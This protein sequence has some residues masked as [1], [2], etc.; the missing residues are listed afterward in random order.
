MV[1]ME[2]QMASGDNEK[3]KEGAQT[4]S[5]PK[6]GLTRRDALLSISAGALSTGLGTAPAMAQMA[7]GHREVRPG[8]PPLKGVRV[9]ERSN[10][11]SGRLAGMLLADQGAE[12]FV[13]RSGPTSSAD[14]GVALDD[15]FFDRGKIAL[16]PGAT[17]DTASAD[18]IIVDGEAKVARASHQILVRVVAALPGDDT[19]GDLPADCSED[20][21][22]A[23]C[24][25]F[26]DM[27]ISGPLL[28]RPVIY[29]PIPL[30]SVYCGVNA[31]VAAVA[32]LV[33]R[34]RTGLGREI[35]AS[36]I[37]GGLS[38]VGALSLTSKG[39]P[40]QLEPIV[41]GGLPPGLS[42]DQF[43]T[44]VAD[45]IRDPERQMWFERR[46]APFST[47]Y[48]TKDGRWYLPMAG[49]NARLSKRLLEAMGVWDEALATGAVFVDPYDAANLADNRRN[50]ADSLSLAF[51]LTSS[52]ADLLE[53]EFV[54]RTAAEWE[55]FLAARGS[56]GS[57]VMTWEEWRNDADA[58]TAGVFVEIPGMEGVQIGRVAWTRGGLPY[59]GLAAA[60]T[61]STIPAEARAHPAASGRA[62]AMRPLEGYKIADMS[63]V[64]A[65]PSCARML[66]E[67]GAEVIRV[68]VMDPQQPPTGVRLLFRASTLT[69]T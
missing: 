45:A 34:L 66:A 47:P 69:A 16:P 37:A 2:R 35:T 49:P 42:P 46:F 67:L 4:G 63:N 15:V 31:A 51:N 68:D 29:T 10:L 27:S 8:T 55:R 19:Y 39:L 54:T 28:G 33:D 12:V 38:A 58:R 48:R 43:Q 14:Q 56:A 3:A 57:I 6:A 7:Q 23:I 11:L 9:V 40:P 36:R 64:L 17:T 61:A 62:K 65:G 1:M 24:G 44:F 52:L 21:I 25:F 41:V 13:E 26:T 50:L 59:S 53:R 60:R 18:I 20:L 22:N 5:G 32:S 30:P